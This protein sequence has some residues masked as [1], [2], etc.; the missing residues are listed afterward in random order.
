[1][2]YTAEIEFLDHCMWGN[3]SK[4]N[5]FEAVRGE[6]QGL[7]GALNPTYFGKQKA[8]KGQHK[9]VTGTLTFENTERGWRLAF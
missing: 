5:S 3:S 1:M 7:L 2:E 9:K 4:N 6:P 8:I